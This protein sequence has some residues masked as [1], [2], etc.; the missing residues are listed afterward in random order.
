M[1]VGICWA[2][3]IKTTGLPLWYLAKM[4]RTNGSAS[5]QVKRVDTAAAAKNSAI[6]LA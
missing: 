2:R 5:N 6:N 3:T 1:L 4:L